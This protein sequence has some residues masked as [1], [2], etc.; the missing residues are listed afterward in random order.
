MAVKVMKNLVMEF[1]KKFDNEKVPADSPLYR[2]V[3]YRIESFH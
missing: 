3:L 1:V 2:H